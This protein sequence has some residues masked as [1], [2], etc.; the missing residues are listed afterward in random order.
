[1]LRASF[2]TYKLV[3]RPVIDSSGRSQSPPQA[4]SGREKIL[5]ITGWDKK[6]SGSLYEVLSIHELLA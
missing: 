2:Q 5:D 3:K 1:L 4:L 6:C